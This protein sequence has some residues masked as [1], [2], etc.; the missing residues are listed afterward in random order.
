MTPTQLAEQ[1]RMASARE[2]FESHRITYSTQPGA[3]G[4]WRLHK[5]GSSDRW[6]E[7][8]DFG[9]GLIVQGDLDLVAFPGK[10]DNHWA[11]DAVRYNAKHA[12]EGGYR[13]KVMIAMSVDENFVTM[14]DEVAFKA[15]FAL[16]YR[17]VYGEWT[18]A[19]YDSPE[20]LFD[21]ASS[22]MEDTLDPRHV[23]AECCGRL[24]IDA[25]IANSDVAAGWGRITRWR[26]AYAVAAIQ[27][28]RD[29]LDAPPVMT[30][31]E[32]IS[33]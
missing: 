27:R 30:K 31:T 11:G 13:K 3:F 8:V 19:V 20:H 32:G 33:D 15:E 5:P 7:I 18:N 24:K 4:Q 16:W 21:E 23:L 26:V 22:D 28:L 2:A 12:D 29:L 25:D 10:K 6:A 14:V 17:D 9:T 1:H